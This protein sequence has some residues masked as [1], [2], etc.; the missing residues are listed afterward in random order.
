MSKLSSFKSFVNE[1]TK[2]FNEWSNGLGNGWV[3]GLATNGLNVYTN[4][5]EWVYRSQEWFSNEWSHEW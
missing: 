4:D 1:W 5:K 3:Y 2:H